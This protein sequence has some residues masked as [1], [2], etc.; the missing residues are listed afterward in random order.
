MRRIEAAVRYPQLRER[1]VR[2]LKYRYHWA[3][4]IVP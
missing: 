3:L 2:T 1:L 4:A